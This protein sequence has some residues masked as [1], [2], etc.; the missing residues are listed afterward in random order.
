MY[1]RRC[2]LDALRSDELA[3]IDERLATGFVLLP[4]NYSSFLSLFLR[5]TLSFVW[6][7]LLTRR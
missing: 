7:L 6:R 1:A 2:T 3:A 5:A 4:E